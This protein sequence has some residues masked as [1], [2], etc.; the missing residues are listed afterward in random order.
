MLLSAVLPRLF[1]PQLVILYA[2]ALSAF[3]IQLRGR[4]RLSFP[5]QLTDH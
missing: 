4:V 1:A 3:L 5:R 2:I